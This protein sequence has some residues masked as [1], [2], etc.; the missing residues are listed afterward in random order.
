MAFGFGAYPK[1]P[2]DG[3]LKSG[4]YPGP[5][6]V[7]GDWWNTDNPYTPPWSPPRGP[8]GKTYT[9]DQLNL[10]YLQPQLAYGEAMRN[11]TNGQQTNF[12]DWFDRQYQNNEQRWAMESAKEGNQNMTLWDW[13]TQNKDSFRNEFNMLTPGRRGVTNEFMGAGRM[14]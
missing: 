1:Q 12:G 8:W 11:L 13:L 10:L 14:V 7:E 3:S 9:Q 4:L 2:M 5:S 6:K